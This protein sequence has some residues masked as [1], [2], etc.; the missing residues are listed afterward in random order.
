MY[1]TQQPV[2]SNIYIPV[3]SKLHIKI[4]FSSDYPLD[5]SRSIRFFLQT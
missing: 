3:P 2:Y 4:L 1:R 5:N